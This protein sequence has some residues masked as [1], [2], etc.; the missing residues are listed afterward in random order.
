MQAITKI[1]LTGGPCAGKSTALSRIGQLFTGLGYKVIFVSE[2]ATD[3]ILGGIAFGSIPTVDFQT[4]VLALQLFREKNFEACA[5]KLPDEKILIV[6]DRG[7]LD[8][9]AYISPDEFAEI[10]DRASTSEA[11]LL[12]N[13]DAVFHLVSSADGAA[14][15]Y[16]TEQ[17]TARTESPEQA[18][19]LDRAVIEAWAGHPHF[20]VI[21]NS[22]GFEEKLRRLMREI[23]HF[24]MR[25]K[26]RQQPQH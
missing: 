21:D 19:M 8:G 24:L 5:R 25:V 2:T 1:A 13:Y 9:K 17:N 12:A 3:L 20:R 11:E 4:S 6:C 14:E 26:P 18:A 15:Y 10:L 16:S 22:T 23:K 7:A